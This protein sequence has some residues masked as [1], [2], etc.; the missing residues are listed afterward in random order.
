M[1]SDGS[2]QFTDPVIVTNKRRYYTAG[3][4][5]CGF[6]DFHN[7]VGCVAKL[8]MLLFKPREICYRSC[9]HFNEVVFRQEIS[10]VPFSVCDIFDD[11]DAQYC[12][13]S[14][15]FTEVLYEHV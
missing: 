5:A 4:V 12:M 14:K 15:L 7:M 3:N 6:S 13:Y 9:K 11:I 10:N 8:T 1:F 2:R